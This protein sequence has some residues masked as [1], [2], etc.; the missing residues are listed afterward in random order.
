MKALSNQEITDAIAKLPEG[1]GW[2]YDG[3]TLN[4]KFE[5]ADFAE[6]F[7]FMTKVAEISEELNH[8]PDWSNVYNIV[9]VKLS[10]HDVHG[11]SERDFKWINKVET[12]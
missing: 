10:S 3:G 8:H 11:I 6:A 4:K 2:K 9:N 1:H 12:L 5:F 7:A